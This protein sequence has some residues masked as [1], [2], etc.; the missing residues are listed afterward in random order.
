MSN[1]DSANFVTKPAW[2]RYDDD[3]SWSGR[4]SFLDFVDLGNNPDDAALLHGSQESGRSSMTRS[5]A[6]ISVF[7]LVITSISGVAVAVQ[8][9]FTASYELLLDGTGF[10]PGGDLWIGSAVLSADGRRILAYTFNYYGDE[11]NLFVVNTTNG[12]RTDVALDPT[13]SWGVVGASMAISEDA[14]VAFIADTARDSIFRVSD[15]TMTKIFDKS[16]WSDINY[17]NSLRTTALGD[18]VYFREDNDDIWVVAAAGGAPTRAVN[19]SEVPRDGGGG[20]KIYT[21]DVSDDGLTIVFGS[22]ATTTVVVIF[23]PGDLVLDGGGFRQLTSD[24]GT[25]WKTRLEVSGDG[26][27]AAIYDQV[28]DWWTAIDVATGAATLLHPTDFDAEG[29]VTLRRQPGILQRR[30]HP[31]RQVDPQQRQ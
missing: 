6:R 4:W 22:W 5:W 29:P 19:D 11:R 10:H 8:P 30:R 1:C 14:S 7:F 17:V 13:A 20:R 28:S 21:F 2:S 18:V 27:T 3:K 26:S 9:D 23:P 15:G 31:R 25:S 24:P 16:D 12:A